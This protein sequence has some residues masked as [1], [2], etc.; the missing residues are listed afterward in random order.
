M[1]TASGIGTSIYTA[2]SDSLS[3][4]FGQSV[5]PVEGVQITVGDIAPYMGV[6]VQV[7]GPTPIP[8]EGDVQIFAD[9]ECTEYATGSVSHVY[10]RVNVPWGFGEGWSKGS[11]TSDSIDCMAPDSEDTGAPYAIL[12]WIDFFVDEER[13]TPY[14]EGEIVALTNPSAVDVTSY[15]KIFS[16][17]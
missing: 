15:T 5:V 6:K 17:T 3:A 1:L 10:A 7:P 13:I 16:K 2:V 8:V 11:Q 14:E 12:L 4:Y 9:P